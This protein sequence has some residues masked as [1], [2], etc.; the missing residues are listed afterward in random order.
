MDKLK[1]LEDN[2]NSYDSP[3]PSEHSIEQASEIL[4]FLVYFKLPPERIMASS[5]GGVSLIFKGVD[6]RRAHIEILN[7]GQITTLLY[8]MEGYS[9]TLIWEGCTEM[10][11]NNAISSIKNWLLL[12]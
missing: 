10:E 11:A 12:T 9:N 6:I 4:K 3:K 7:G 1:T 5:I 8:N 2:W